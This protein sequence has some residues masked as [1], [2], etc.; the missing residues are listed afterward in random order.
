M[1]TKLVFTKAGPVTGFF[2]HSDVSP[3]FSIYKM[4]K[5]LKGWVIGSFK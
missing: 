2:D 1:L 3:V 5:I 4:G